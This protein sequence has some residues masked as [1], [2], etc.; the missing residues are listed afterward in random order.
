[1]YA[2]GWL[3][4]RQDLRPSTH[5]FYTT[6]LERHL[7]P[8][9]GTQP[10]NEISPSMVRSWFRSYGER[11]PTA[12][13]HANQVLV[14]VM[15]QAEADDL[16]ARTPCR[17][18]ADGRTP[19]KRETEVLSL[20]ELLV[21]AHAMPPQHRALVLLCGLAG[22]RF[23]ELSRCAAATWTPTPGPSP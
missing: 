2:R 23:G 15:A 11:T 20:P 13:A 6:A 7:V 5:V 1:M 8:T 4:G 3:A 9:F 18:K 12:R 10:V 17:V 16:I 19:V 14:S 22:L 21:Q